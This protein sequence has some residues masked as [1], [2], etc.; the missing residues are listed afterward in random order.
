[1]VRMEAVAGRL[2]LILPAAGYPQERLKKKLAS[3]AAPAYERR[4]TVFL[5]HYNIIE[6]VLASNVRYLNLSR[7]HDELGHTRGLLPWLLAPRCETEGD[8]LG[9]Y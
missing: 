6:G 3:R 4:L 5:T 1:M 9:G 7:G 2:S 8:A